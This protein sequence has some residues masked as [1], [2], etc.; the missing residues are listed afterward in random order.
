[1]LGG[2]VVKGPTAW[3]PRREAVLRVLRPALAG[4]KVPLAI[5]PTPETAL[6]RQA[7]GARWIYRQTPDGRVDRSG[8]KK[9]NSPWADVGDAACYVIGWLVRGGASDHAGGPR[10]PYQARMAAP[11][12]GA[13]RT[14][15][16][17][18][19]APPLGQRSPS[20]I[21]GIG[22]STPWPS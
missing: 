8:A 14:Y 17:K 22:A 11:P 21:S 15:T 12:L 5:S 6:L 19:A 10:A 4:G 16:A 13:G 9:P 2:R 7:F 1:V 20:R 3:P 18:M